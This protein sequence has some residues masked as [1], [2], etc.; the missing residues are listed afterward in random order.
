MEFQDE[1]NNIMKKNNK[2]PKIIEKS[3]QFIFKVTTQNE[4]LN[5]LLSFLIIEEQ[6]QFQSILILAKPYISPSKNNIEE[7]KKTLTRVSYREKFCLN[8]FK[9]ISS[10]YKNEKNLKM[11]K[12]FDDIIQSVKEKKS[13]ILINKYHLVFNYLLNNDKSNWNNSII[14][15]L[16][17][18][19]ESNILEKY[20]ENNSKKIYKNNNNENIENI[21]K[22]NIY[23]SMN[24][25]ND[26][27]NKE[28]E[29][30]KHKEKN[31]EKNMNKNNSINLQKTSNHEINLAKSKS[32]NEKP[33][34]K[35]LKKINKSNTDE[36]K[37]ESHKTK[38]VKYINNNNSNS[39]KNTENKDINITKMSQIENISNEQ[40][41]IITKSFIYGEYN[42]S[43]YVE[44]FSKK[45]EVQKNDNDKNDFTDNEESESWG[46]SL[47][48]D[49]DEKN[50]EN[51]NN[52][53]NNNLLNNK[54]NR[55]SSKSKE[56]NDNNHNINI[57][58]ENH[59]VLSQEN[60]HKKNENDFN[61][62]NENENNKNENKDNNNDNTPIIILSE[63]DEEN[64][65]ENENGNEQQ[66]SPN[67]T[68]NE[69]SFQKEK[70]NNVLINPKIKSKSHQNKI[71]VNNNIINEVLNNSS[72]KLDSSYSSVSLAEFDPPALPYPPR[73]K[74]FGPM[75][76]YLSEPSDI[77]NSI[78]D[79]KSI[80]DRIEPYNKLFFKLIYTSKKDK[81]K[82]E[83]F[84]KA[85]LD[86]FRLLIL[87]KTKKNKKFAIYFNEKLFSSKGKQEQETV[88]IMSFIYSFE[89]KKFFYPKERN[90]CFTQSPSEPYLF[91][92]SDHSIY[93]RDNFMSE[94]HYLTKISKVYSINNLFE[95]LNGGDKEFYLSVLE[96]YNAE[97]SEK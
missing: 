60:N 70:T 9:D 96:I 97:N 20:Y 2:Y 46:E 10:F 87:I 63:D 45:K 14:L 48:L 47:F 51:E 88:D 22:K 43:S 53:D 82:Y 35:S 18:E 23:N 17:N 81:D 38:K 68:Q 26:E 77:I 91:K 73:K 64:E 6:Y 62:L 34:K 95:E 27:Q 50:L 44:D 78:S 3:D 30:E 85:V 83:E 57:K 28:K 92:L 31:I 25:Y 41:E 65:D 24:I 55:S 86:K 39:L 58:K 66:E 79:I 90:F 15:C 37:I 19:M 12:I 69:D 80:K 61:E 49:K 1:N 21:N 29:K 56:K 16:D 13:R 42:Y 75:Q 33:K 7:I 76:N 36:Q 93:L 32:K 71:P 4:N 74:N 84:K 8:D 11:K 40:R 5:F 59:N 72:E 89:S 52:N 94:K 67:I 54:R